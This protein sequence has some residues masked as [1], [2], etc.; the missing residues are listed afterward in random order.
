MAPTPALSLT[1]KQIR[2]ELAC[3]KLVLQASIEDI[4]LLCFRFIST[5]AED[6]EHFQGGRSQLDPRVRPTPHMQRLA[7][8]YLVIDKDGHP[9]WAR[10]PEYERLGVIAESLGLRWGGRWASLNDIYHVEYQD[11]V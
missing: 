11:G 7:K 4:R 10:T 2:F 1:E 8:D 6:L 9:V 5:L 3:S